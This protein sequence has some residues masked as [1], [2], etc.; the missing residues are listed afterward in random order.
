[1]VTKTSFLFYFERCERDINDIVYFTCAP[2]Y[3][4]NHPLLPSRCFV[5]P[6]RFCK[7]SLLRLDSNSIV[8]G[9]NETNLR[10]YKK[11]SKTKISALKLNL[12]QQILKNNY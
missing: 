11:M 10:R 8:D 5:N 12:S 3:T 4:K 2:A 6:M 7:F 1:M 9:Y